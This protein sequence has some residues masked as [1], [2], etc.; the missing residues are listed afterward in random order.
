MLNGNNKKEKLEVFDFTKEKIL[1]RSS[2]NIIPMN[3]GIG[4]N[5]IIPHC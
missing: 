2:S 4:C 1:C 3:I 5:C